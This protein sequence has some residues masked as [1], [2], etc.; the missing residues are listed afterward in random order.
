MKRIRVSLN[1]DGRI[2]IKL[3]KNKESTPDFISGVPEVQPNKD[4]RKLKSSELHEDK[5]LLSSNLINLMEIRAESVFRPNQSDVEVIYALSGYEECYPDKMHNFSSN[6]IVSNATPEKISYYTGKMVDHI[7]QERVNKP[8]SVI[9]LHTH[10]SGI[11][12]LSDQDKISHPHVAKTIQERI[13][14][15][16]VLF[17]VHSVSEEDRRVRTDPLK[18]VSNKIKWSSIT[19]DHEIAFFTEDSKPYEVEIW[20][21]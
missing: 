18:S 6:E 12:E 4:V 13:S 9:I 17:G 10:P 16:N 14:G 8:K 21:V 3:K 2:H 15:V 11:S 19:R 5:I 1:G 20:K 7:N